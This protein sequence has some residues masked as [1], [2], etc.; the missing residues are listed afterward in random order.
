[1]RKEASTVR[2][3]QGPAPASLPTR[4]VGIRVGAGVPNECV[5]CTGLATGSATGSP[6]PGDGLGD[7]LGTVPG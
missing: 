4:E 1:M 5:R 7:G 3:P 6:P 2:S